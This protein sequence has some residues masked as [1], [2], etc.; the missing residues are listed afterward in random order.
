MASILRKL[1]N[2][3]SDFR[4]QIITLGRSCEEQDKREAVLALLPAIDQIQRTIDASAPL[5]GPSPVTRCAFNF[6]G[7]QHKGATLLVTPSRVKAAR[8]AAS[9]WCRRHG[10]RLSVNATPDGGAKVTRLDGPELDEGATF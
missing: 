1:T 4:E 3:V 7:M 2:R 5:R 8:V 10:W 9:A 6:A